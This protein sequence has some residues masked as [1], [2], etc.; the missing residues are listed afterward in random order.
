[1]ASIRTREGR[2]QARVTRQ[3]FPTQVKTFESK[4]LAVKWARSVEASMDAGGRF[5][6]SDILKWPL[7]R[8]LERYLKEVTPSKRGGETEATRLQAMMRWRLGG[9]SLAN[10]SPERVAEQ[11]DE[12]LKTVGAATV[13]RDLA[14]LSG[15]INHARREW[16]PSM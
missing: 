6:P 4:A 1:M 2:W 13:I 5:G 15:V 9:F 12:R 11:R 3:G 7:S 10:L 8:L 14:L 16:G